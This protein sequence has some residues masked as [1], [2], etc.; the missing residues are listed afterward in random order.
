MWKNKEKAWYSQLTPLNSWHFAM[1]NN[2]IKQ[3][4]LKNY[5]KIKS[6]DL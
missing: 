5:N 2:Q 6:D 1:K 4:Q 3:K